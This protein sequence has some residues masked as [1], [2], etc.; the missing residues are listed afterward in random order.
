MTRARDSFFLP[1]AT[2][3]LREVYRCTLDS[4][5][6]TARY[7]G[8]VSA[9]INR[10]IVAISQP[11]SSAASL[12]E[13][14]SE[15]SIST[16]T[17][18]RATSYMQVVPIISGSIAGSYVEWNCGTSLIQS[19]L[20]SLLYFGLKARINPSSNS[21]ADDPSTGIQDKQALGYSVGI[22]Y[23][24]RWDCQRTRRLTAIPTYNNTSSAH[25][26]YSPADLG[27]SPR[28]AMGMPGISRNT[29]YADSAVSG[30]SIYFFAF[31]TG[32][33]TTFLAPKSCDSNPFSFRNLMTASRTTY[34]EFRSSI[35]AHFA[36]AS[37]TS[38]STRAKIVSFIALILADRVYF[39]NMARLLLTTLDIP[40]TIYLTP[41]S[42]TKRDERNAG[43]SHQ[44]QV[45]LLNG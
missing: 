6:G 5:R 23:K 26:P 19:G 34:E 39:V 24:H 16:P 13:I 28:L 33:S 18:V 15:L 37:L 21:L 12:I 22:E 30:C 43:P 32:V 10:L 40:A 42:P 14:R 7:S 8:N 11:N 25:T 20:P 17:S 29:A 9:C 45:R 2:T 36:M 44:Q 31:L 35:S 41:N 3:D 4:K 38:S 1:Y 27:N